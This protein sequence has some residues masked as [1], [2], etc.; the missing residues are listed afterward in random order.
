MSRSPERKLLR[1]GQDVCGDEPDWAPEAD[2]ALFGLETG[3]VESSQVKSQPSGALYLFLGQ[4]HACISP[5]PH[6]IVAIF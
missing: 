2:E 4:I 5:E 6:C 3:H 1:A